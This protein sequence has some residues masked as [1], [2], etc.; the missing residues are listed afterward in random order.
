MEKDYSKMV[1]QTINALNWTVI[2]ACYQ[3][4]IPAQFAERKK[5]DKQTIKKELKDL[6]HFIIDT[7]IKHMEHESWVIN[8]EE[9]HKLEVLFCPTKS[10]VGELED[11]STESDDEQEIRE[12]TVLLMKSEKEE[13]YE[14]CA[15]IKSNIK[16][17]TRVRK[18]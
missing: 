8:W 17:L 18:H 16:K 5:L 11:V 7:N 6:L 1:E 14:L 9:D 15:A 2:L 4:D 3:E 12:L 10:V 13:K